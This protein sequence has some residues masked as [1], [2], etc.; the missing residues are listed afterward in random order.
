M[1]NAE[2][3]TL[4]FLLKNE[5][6]LILTGLITG[7]LI[8]IFY[9]LFFYVALYNSN[10]KIYVK[11]IA[12]S[13]FVASLDAGSSLVSESG[14]SNP[15]FN[16]YEVLKSENI[17]YKI[18]PVIKEKYP[19]D[20]AI[21]EA[22]S[23]ESFFESYKNLINANAVPSTDIIVLKFMWPNQKHAPVVLN[24]VLQK[25]K[26]ENLKIK[27]TGESQK[28]QFI[29]KQ[30]MEISK[31]LE[32]VRKKIKNY[33][34]NTG[35]VNIDIETENI[36]NQR[37]E[38]EKQA[39]LLYSQIQYNK[40]K[41]NEFSTELKIKNAEIALRATGIGNDPYL[42]KLSLDLALAK[43]NH[44]KLKAKFKNKYIDVISTKNEI[45][46]LQDLI[47]T[48]KEETSANTKIPRAIYDGPSSQ[49]VTNFALTQAE[50]VAL[51][52]QFRTLKASVMQLKSKEGKLPKAQLGLDEIEKI[53]D[54]LAGAYKNIKEKQLEATIKENEIIDNIIILSHP[55]RASSLKLFLV[56]RF[57]GF[58]LLGGLLGLA[59][60]YAKQ[61]L[62]DK[63]INTEEM[64]LL[65]GQNIL[66]PIP[67]V[68]DFEIEIAKK[69]I[70]AAYTN[71]AS[72]IVSKAYLNEA[73]IISFISMSKN[74]TKSIITENIAHKV[75]EMD[76]PVLLID[77]V[78]KDINDFD[79]IEAVKLIN[80]EIR[81]YDEDKTLT[82][83]HQNMSNNEQIV[84][85]K[86]FFKKIHDILK[87]AIKKQ[88]HNDGSEIL[89]LNKIETNIKSENLNDFIASKGFKYILKILKIHYEFIFINAPHGF[90]LLPEIQTLKKLPEGIVLISSMDTHK[91]ELI[92][93]VQNISD[94]EI[95]IL[96]IIAREEH[97]ELEKH[98]KTLEQH[99]NSEQ[100]QK[101]IINV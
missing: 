43:Q 14:Y 51:Q 11:N 77:L 32:E 46:E 18:Y 4:L 73:F 57:L 85:N 70:N 25:F 84:D 61:A 28:R 13:D 2:K 56:T 72:E 19:E 59:I 81:D 83:S 60:A 94:P 66:G 89:C 7:L 76:K 1:F 49:I 98:I 55:S 82:I 27:K 12:K 31:Q 47:N 5:R 33:K 23:K 26:E 65:T 54:A 41:S 39:Y 63:W 79:L 69:I 29:D 88:F 44:A 96:G 62:E 86:Q 67:W 90:I 17:A 42:M 80:K 15:L 20:L 71:I 75:A 21:L 95:K 58:L 8:F 22:Y 99:K 45:N 74:Q 16:L 64:K 6:K 52:A 53:E 48:R 38:L 35:I 34:L 3:N 87:G 92:K 93:L 78:S 36:I 30:T 37:M 50:M 10:C 101:A 100:D 68:K 91:Q 9:Y 24:E 97:S 40:R